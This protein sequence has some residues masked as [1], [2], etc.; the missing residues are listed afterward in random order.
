MIAIY[1]WI[2]AIAYFGFALWCTIAPQAT[3]SAIGFTFSNSSA[4]S[5]YITVY[6]GLE[7]A[8]AV[9]FLLGA[10]REDLR[11]PALVFAVCLY[12]GLVLFRLGT[13]ITLSGLSRMIFVLFAMEMALAVAGWALLLRKSSL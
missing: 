8:M 7:A 2:N 9:F 11:W 4:R 10:L 13:L 12:S 3:A 6:G 1:L 5:E